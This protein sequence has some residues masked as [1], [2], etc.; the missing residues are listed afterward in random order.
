MNKDVSKKINKKIFTTIKPIKLLDKDINFNNKKNKKIE[1]APT[2]ECE[3]YQEQIMKVLKVLGH[4]EALVTDMSSIGDFLD[5]FGSKKQTQSRLKQIS[6][7]LGFEVS[8]NDLIVE[9]AKEI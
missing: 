9:V 1:L 5:V 2:D 7:K 4:D 6:K 3:K 8:T